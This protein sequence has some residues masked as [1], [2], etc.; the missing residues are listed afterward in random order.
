MIAGSRPPESKRMQAKLTVLLAIAM[1]AL[2]VSCEDQ[3]AGGLPTATPAPTDAAPTATATFL[4]P[5]TVTPYP[6]A[7]PRGGGPD[8]GLPPPDSGTGPAASPASAATS[9]ETA[10]PSVTSLPPSATAVPTSSLVDL[11]SGINLGDRIFSADFFQG[12]PSENFPTVKIALK[13]GQYAFEIGPQDAGVISSSVVQA[14]NVFHQIEFTPKNCPDGAG[15]GL[16]IRQKDSGN[17]Y[18]F[19][20]FCD[21]TFKAA[22]VINGT[23]TELTSGPLPSGSQPGASTTHIIGVA[24]FNT[25]FT[26]YFDQQVIGTASDTQVAQGD[27]AFYAFSQESSVLQVAFD[28]WQVWTLR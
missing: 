18:R 14:G 5:A 10:I 2:S 28:N 19:S 24:A 8:V 27:V 26:Y 3:S 11:P 25:G 23:V 7:T 17:Y 4:P 20:V 13:D 16:R 12:W 9:P 21:N 1:L 15:F 6:T 22:V